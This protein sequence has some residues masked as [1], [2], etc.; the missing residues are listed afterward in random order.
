MD[1]LRFQSLASGSSGNC[2]YV[3]NS[4]HGILIDAG[5]GARTIRKCLRNIGLDFENIWGVFITHDHGDHI[6][7][8]G[9]LGEKF[10]LP[11]YATREVH[12]GINR[13]YC[14]TQKLSTCQKYIEKYKTIEVAGFSVTA[15]PVSH[16]ATDNVG[17][18]IEYKGK[19]ITFATDL[20]V[21]GDEV[22]R[23][24]SESDYLILEA[25]Y[26]EDMLRNGTYPHY[27]KQRIVSPTGHLSNKQA[28]RCLAEYYHERLQHVFLCHLSKENNQPELAYNT[29]RQHLEEKQIIVGENLSLTTLERFSPSELYVF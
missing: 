22:V 9:T 10:H 29:V 25:N 16:D 15:F 3:G 19:K 2:Y 7:G 4:S 28:G 27:L 26:D 12:E 24:I 20:G 18:T 13:N 21:V 5:I 11:V 14:V 23:Q 8:V 6:R 17:Y 1:K